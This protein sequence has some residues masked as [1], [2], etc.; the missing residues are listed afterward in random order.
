M[1]FIFRKTVRAGRAARL[2]LSG[3]GVS[4]SKKVGRVT[5]NSRGKVFVRLFPGFTWR[6]K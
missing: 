5:V 4:A 6:S 2:N 3:G 1:G